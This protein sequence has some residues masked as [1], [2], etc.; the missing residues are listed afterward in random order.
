VGAR[1]RSGGRAN[2]RAIPDNRDIR[3]SSAQGFQKKISGKPP[4]V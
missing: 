2:M 4:H 3:D 1:A